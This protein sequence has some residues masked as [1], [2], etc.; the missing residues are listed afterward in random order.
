MF[1]MGIVNNK[2][3]LRWNPYIIKYYTQKGYT[4]TKIGEP[5]TVRV[6]DLNPNSNVYMNVKCDYCGNNLSRKY[7]NIYDSIN[8]GLVNKYACHTCQSKKMY[9]ENEIKLEM[10]TLSKS[11]KGYWMFKENR[12]KELYSFLEKN[13]NSIDN[14][15]NLSHD[16]YRAIYDYDGSLNN[17]LSELEIEWNEVCSTK[18]NLYE[19]FDVFKEKIQSF[20]N[21]YDKFPTKEEINNNLKISQWFIDM[22]GGMYEIKRKMNYNDIND[23]V[24]D[25]G[26]INKSSYEY[27]VAQFLIHNGV[28]YKRE[29]YPF[30]K[31]EGYYRSDFMFE[32]LDNE[33][34]HAE[35]WGFDD[36]YHIGEI[37]QQYRTTKQEKI[38]LYNKYKIN[39]ISI[40]YN[41]MSKSSLSVIQEY[42]KEQFSVINGLL[43]KEVANE[44]L[45]IPSSLSEDEILET[46]MKFSDNQEYLPTQVVLLQNGLWSYCNEI[47]KRYG[48]YYK[49]AEK[50]NKKRQDK[51]YDWDE[52]TIYK[53]LLNIVKDE[54]PIKK[55]TLK[56]FGYM[57]MTNKRDENG[58][59]S[60]IPVRLDFYQKY[61]L[62]GESYIHP[63]DVKFLN[64]VVQ[65]I[66]ANVKNK[67]TIEQQKQALEILKMYQS[68][69]QQP[70]NNAI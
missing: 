63:E 22:H 24:D 30:P 27:I 10:G 15:V 64:N 68:N 14:M 58:S 56:E 39:L 62:N 3:V 35:V 12:I 49:F 2:V 52:E 37:N 1:K 21:K 19:D 33:I 28:S 44:V 31:D 34:F 17:I 23:L 20:I 70:L 45:L 11:D 18:K 60:L 36:K 4:Y 48:D 25:N 32:T 8:N 69:N 51:T 7:K 67:V 38:R 42:L 16:L 65:N 6:E 13:N 43:L 26:F 40:D 57:G 46:I 5:F 29:Q 53:A 54:K 59:H 9:E 61:L 41:I 50:V 47:R 66:G 55:T